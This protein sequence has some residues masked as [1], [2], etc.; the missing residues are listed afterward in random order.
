[1]SLAA[2]GRSGRSRSKSPGGRHRE[3]S[4]S[5]ARSPT[6]DTEVVK[7]EYAEESYN[8]PP[9]P[10]VPDA[11]T[12]HLSQGRHYS[13]SQPHTQYDTR[14]PASP[15]PGYAK[16]GQYQHADPSA[17]YQHPSHESMP[18]EFPRTHEYAQVTHE[19][20][21]QYATP[22]RYEYSKNDHQDRRG[23]PHPE[24]TRHLSFSTG[25][26]FHVDIGGGQGSHQHDRPEYVQSPSYAYAQ[27]PPLAHSE[28]GHGHPSTRPP[29]RGQPAHGPTYASPSE[30]QYARPDERI[31]YK[32]KQ[33]KHSGSYEEK[34][35]AERIE[36]QYKQGKHSGS[37]AEKEESTIIEV[38]PG[39]S[40]RP[41]PSPGLTPHMHRLSVSG[42]APGSLG[43]GLGHGHGHGGGGLPPGSP[44]LEAYH[45]TYQSMSPMP[46]PMALPASLDDGLDDLDTLSDLDS[47]DDP[48]RRTGSKRVK[49]YDPEDDAKA[50]SAALR[51]RTVDE[52]VLIEV[53]P[54]L[55]H[56][57]MLLLRTEYKKHAKVQGKG[58]NIAKH[59]KMKCPTSS[60]GKVA[61][62][63]ALGQW[64]SEAHWAN[65]WYQSHTSRRELL[66]ESLMG[67]TNAEIREIKEAFSDK[68]YNDSLEK[69][70]K[71][72][73]KA[74]KFRTAVLLVLEEKRME[75]SNV[76]RGDVVRDD[77]R[78]LY[79]A[80]SGRSG[81]ETVMIQIV[82]TRSDSHLREVLRVYEKTYNKNFAKEMLR[83]STNLVGETL[84]HILNGLINRPVR[85]ALLLHQAIEETGKERTE[86]LI[87]R[88]VR[89]HWDRPHLERVK[90]EFRARYGEELAT[91]LAES[92]K[93]DFGEFCVEL[94]VRR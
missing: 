30:Y 47:S 17:Y 87:S 29:V 11:P 91:A 77:V 15:Q 5:R 26:N 37:Y 94:V 13:Y 38:R 75:E 71:A 44:L 61:Y 80:L 60:F 69:C 10:Q 92:T 78:R 86:L 66:I 62:A 46:S 33:G 58:I 88:L 6:R 32:Y 43:H 85:D 84:A 67:R 81:G 34:D 64:E 74:D 53:L 63:T 24:A 73:L 57:H 23:P 45:G 89:Y 31:Q 48:R 93:G 28:S 12:G 20:R 21:T 68:R 65:L 36:Y 2:P 49:F 35:E 40:H 52:A 16:P 8:Y 18:G 3:R 90:Q 56:D 54:G 14:P 83:K 70:M 55:T 9:A 42:G 50:L 72:E 79:D 41:P 22:G 51:G 27:P 25:G 59:I 76:L 1:M 4:T 7:Y 19:E 82:V 39:G